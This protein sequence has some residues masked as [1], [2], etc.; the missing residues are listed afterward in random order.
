MTFEIMQEKP[1]R[2]FQIPPKLSLFYLLLLMHWVTPFLL[3]Y[4]TVLLQTYYIIH[5]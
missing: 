1:P 4:P 5:V 3:F 2:T